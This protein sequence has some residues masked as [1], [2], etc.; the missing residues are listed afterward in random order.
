MRII[1]RHAQ[2][3]ACKANQYIAQGNTWGGDTT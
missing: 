3:T 2:P 1:I